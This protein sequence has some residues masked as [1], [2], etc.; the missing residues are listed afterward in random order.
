VPTEGCDVI[1]V[2][3]GP[4]GLA[5]AREL[6]DS[7]LSVLI[8][9]KAS[10]L[11]N[12][13][14]G[15]GICEKEVAV[16]YEA[17]WSKKTATQIIRAGQRTVTINRR[18]KRITFEREDLASYQERLLQDAKNITV[19]KNVLVTEILPGSIKTTQGLYQYKYLVGADGSAS[20]VRAY[21]KLPNKL[22]LGMYYRIRGTFDAVVAYYDPR[23]MGP[24]Y[25]WEFPHPTYTNIGIYF[26]PCFLDARQAKAILQE[27]LRKRN[28]TFFEKDFL[29]API[30]YNY[31]GHQFGDIYLI[32]DA[33]GFACRMHGG[34]IN[35]AIISGTEIAKR[36]KDAG[37]TAKPLRDMIRSK[38]SSDKLIEYFAV[39]PVWLAQGVI[40]MIMHLYRVPFFQKLL[41]I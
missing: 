25:I 28:Y 40:V 31:M 35:N 9:D 20:I 21:L 19:L 39:V 30:N 37:Y 33:G 23:K 22:A 34:G 41:P 5:C 27:Y 3:G 12:K 14:C 32:G 11:G 26:E 10:V 24:G 18:Y 16:P 2:G 13:P 17:R 6:A 36:I 29:T 7:E 8:L 15:G 38:Q 1:I 4:A